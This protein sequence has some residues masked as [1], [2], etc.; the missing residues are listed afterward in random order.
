MNES[1]IKEQQ[2]SSQ[3]ATVTDM[4][5][6]F[7]LATDFNQDIG[8]WDVSSVTNMSGMFRYTDV[9][10]QDIGG[11][12]VS[13]VTDMED[14]FFYATSFNQDLSGW[15]VSTFS[16]QPSDFDSGA[17]SWTLPQPVWGTCP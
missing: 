15:C 16:S 3:R 17:S 6:M 5:S 7:F 12:D 14:M 9:F 8:G 1:S 10:N 11:W 4:S 13:S 2:K